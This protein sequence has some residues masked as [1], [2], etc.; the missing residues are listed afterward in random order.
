MNRLTL[1]APRLSELL[2]LAALALGAQ[3]GAQ[4][5]A[6]G[7]SGCTALYSL[8]NNNINYVAPDGTST[9]IATAVGTAVNGAALDPQTGNVYYINRTSAND[10]RVFDPDT[11]TD[12]QV[13]TATVPLP[14][15]G[16][17]VVGG[18]FDSSTGSS[19]LFVLYSSY[20]I[21]E[22][23]KVT[24]AVLRTYTIEL[25]ATN[26]S[27]AALTKP[28]STSG[29]FVFDGSTLYAVI[30][31]TAGG[32]TSRYY[33]TLGSPPVTAVGTTTTLTGTRAVRI[34]DSA[35]AN[36][37]TSLVGIAINPVTTV[38]QPTPQIYVT[39][40]TN[41]YTLNPT[42]GNLTLTATQP[43]GASFTDLSDC[44]VAPAKPQ[45]T[46]AFAATSIRNGSAFTTRLT[47][48]IANTNPASYYTTSTIVD[49][50]PAGLVIASTPN[51]TTTCELA[52]GSTGLTGASAPAG[53]TVITIPKDLRIPGPTVAPATPTPGG[54]NYA[55]DITGTTR[56]AK[57]NVISAS[58]VNT[59]AGQ[60]SADATATLIVN[61]PVSATVV[62]RQ[63]VVPIGTEPATTLGTAAVSARPGRTIEYCITATHGGVGFADSTKAV[64]GDVLSNNLELVPNVY[65]GGL[66]DVSIQRGAATPTYA[67]FATTFAPVTTN[68]VTQQ[69]LSV[70]ILPL[71]ASNPTVTVCFQARVK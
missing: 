4:N 10:L 9:R 52:A 36:F 46:K 55:L 43:S 54:C 63:R 28:A 61:D 62:K 40:T 34:N 42:T 64:I 69:V 49:N 15:S 59:S 71:N 66:S 13:G 29:D 37:T 8:A 48:S 16:G 14:Q 53:G 30:D 57:N 70:N 56:G 11:R 50:L 5:A 20:V 2:A 17:S 18:S 33:V 44:A 47:I 38:A 6:P 51:F 60:P 32:T 58:T 39:S 21:Q 41:I 65:N 1:R 25:P 67:K 26:S 24:G 19:R 22:L 68:G 27:G 7:T 3:A 31:G 23:N 45:I 35:G 12:T